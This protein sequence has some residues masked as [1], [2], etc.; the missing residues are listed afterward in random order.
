[1][2]AWR[3]IS[4]GNPDR[5]VLA[6]DFDSTARPEAGFGTFAALLEPAREIWLTTQPVEADDQLL[7]ADTYLRWWRER[8]S[9][10]VD[11]IMGYCVGAVFAPFLAAAIDGEQG[12]RPA[13]LLVDPEPVVPMSLYRD[14]TKAVQTM[15]ILSEEERAGHLAEALSVCRT[16]ETDFATTARAIGKLYETAAGT[17]F[18]RLG[19][20]DE[21]REELL[22]L[23]RSYLSYLAAAHQL[24]PEQGWTEAVALTSVKSSPGAPYA[25]KEER[26]SVD[27]A[28]MLN[29]RPL[30]EAVHRFLAGREAQEA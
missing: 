10:R 28:E 25:R 24:S 29:H 15:A 23:F 22:A 4:E 18:D 27:T 20:D 16:T 12:S 6:V 26:F 17:A 1:M 5:T 7:S 19:L 8:P 9:G 30:A 21:S 3:R 2:N 14:F 13:L 11:T